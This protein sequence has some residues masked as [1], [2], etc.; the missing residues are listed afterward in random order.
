[1]HNTAGVDPDAFNDLS[2]SA[3][4]TTDELDDGVDEDDPDED[5]DEDEDGDE[6]E[7]DTG[8][9]SPGRRTVK[10]PRWRFVYHRDVLIA[11]FNSGV[12]R[13][14]NCSSALP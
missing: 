10:V 8:I 6:E 14:K 12:D 13:K 1:M 9:K 11:F 3:A 4:E 7:E 5:D 2:R